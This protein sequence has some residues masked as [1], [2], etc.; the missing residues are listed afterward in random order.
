MDSTLTAFSTP[1]HAPNATGRPDGAMTPPSEGTVA[2]GFRDLVEGRGLDVVL[3]P[4]I[5]LQ[6]GVEMGVEA[7][8]RFDGPL[9]TDA[10]F[11]M[12]HAR[13]LGVDLELRCLDRVLDHVR[14]TD[15]SSPG[16]VGVNLSAAALADPRCLSLLEGQP[17]HRL[18]VELTDQTLAPEL[19]TLRRRV[20]EVRDLGA[21]I[22]L[23]VAGSIDTVA[24]SVIQPEMAK[25]RVAR[26]HD[27]TCDNSKLARFLS[28]AGVFVIAVGADRRDEI[29]MFQAHG[30]DAAQG[31]M[32]GLPRTARR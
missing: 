31:H 10:V 28:G 7:L 6:T 21:R 29:E 18:V 24:F 20:D 11:R 8:A 26:W 12:A 19:A 17:S 27:A 25:L 30:V 15:G 23:H 9:A 14:A 2:D 3:E 22:A 4:I 16:F 13:G 5:H 1:P 32:Y